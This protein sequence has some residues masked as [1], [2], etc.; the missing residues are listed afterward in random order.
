M[1][2]ILH[3]LFSPALQRLEQLIAL[4]GVGYTLSTLGADYTDV[5]LWAVVILVLVIEYLA[6]QQGLEAGR[7]E[8]ATAVLA[9]N[10]QDLDEVRQLIS[11]LE[12]GHLTVEELEALLN[13]PDKE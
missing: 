6:H 12:S 11:R 10:Q 8:G 5:R 13:K 2:T 1:N 9:M 3:I 7:T 4:A